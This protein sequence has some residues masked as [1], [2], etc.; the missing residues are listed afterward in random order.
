MVAVIGV[1]VL[2]F[3]LQFGGKGRL[4][5]HKLKSIIQVGPGQKAD[6]AL[7]AFS[8][9]L[10]AQIGSTLA[11]LGIWEE[12]IS[13]RKPLKAGAG[14]ILVQ[15]PDDL[16]LVVCNLELSRLAKGLGGE[17]IK[18]VEYPGKDKV[19]LQVGKQGRVT[20]EIV[21]V[22]NRQ[23]RRRAG[24]IALIVDDFGADMEIARRF[25]ELDPRVTLSV[26]P[27]LKHSQQVAELA[28]KSGHEVLLHLP[29]EPEDESKNNPGKGAILVRQSSSQ[30]RTLTRRALASVPHAKG[31]NNHM[32][33]RATESLRVMKAVLR[34]IKKR[35]L[36]F[37]DSMT[38][39]QSVG[40]S[41]AK[42]MGI[43]CAQR[44]L[45]IDNQDDPKAIETRLLE[46]SR[47]AAE[48]QKAIGIGH[49][50]ENTLKALEQMLPKLQK[51]G[52][53]LVSAS[54]M[55]E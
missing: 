46:L 27:Y 2:A 49:A 30:I 52:F 20:E 21:L 32:G 17:V 16:P 22:K 55:V 8:D 12:L 42:S 9:S 4:F 40:Y 44:D 1:L 3:S 38:S 35:G 19:V 24:T 6:E 31:V 29:M 10:K 45:F 14:R 37:I 53:K 54:K 15:V 34:E 26:L 5:Y 13:E 41:T 39:S 36:F 33:S 7:Q 50:R 25:C 11:E 51:R 18:A 28:F 23:Q 48:Q 43:R 47:L